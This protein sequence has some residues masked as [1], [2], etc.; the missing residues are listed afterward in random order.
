[1]ASTQEDAGKAHL[2]R[3]IAIRKLDK[4]FLEKHESA[5]PSLAIVAAVVLV[6]QMGIAIFVAPVLP[7]WAFWTA[8]ATIGA[9]LAHMTFLGMHEAVHDHFFPESLQVSGLGC[10]AVC[11]AVGWGAV[12]CGGTGFTFTTNSAPHPTLPAPACACRRCRGV[13]PCSGPTGSR[14]SWSRCRC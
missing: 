11:S 1:M 10:S 9:L 12:R 14:V 5:D 2:Q 4:A 7:T 13:V 3:R 8:C 6:A